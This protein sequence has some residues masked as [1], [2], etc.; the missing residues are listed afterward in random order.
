MV[1]RRG[2][3]ASN[4][5]L[6]WRRKEVARVKSCTKVAAERGGEGRCSRNG[7]GSG[8]ASSRKLMKGERRSV[9]GSG[10]VSKGGVG[11]DAVRWGEAAGNRREGWCPEREGG[12]SAEGGKGPS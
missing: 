6:S 3:T 8:A 10:S 5:R 1:C 2:G 9:S 11:R 7:G 4:S 12:S